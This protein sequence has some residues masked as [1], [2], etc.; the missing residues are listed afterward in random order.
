MYIPCLQ[1]EIQ[2]NFRQGTL[3]NDY[4]HRIF[5]ISFMIFQSE[6]QRN[7]ASY[8]PSFPTGPVPKRT[9]KFTGTNQ[10]PLFFFIYKDVVLNKN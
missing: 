2:N 4:G 3:E 6:L 8:T 9:F 10:T 1:T 5:V 7:V